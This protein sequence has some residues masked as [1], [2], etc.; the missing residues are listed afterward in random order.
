VQVVDTLL[1]EVVTA[2]MERSIDTAL[3][4]P[5]VLD[6]I[7]SVQQQQRQQQLE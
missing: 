1:D 4:E 7:L 3:L 5:M 2:G 6:R